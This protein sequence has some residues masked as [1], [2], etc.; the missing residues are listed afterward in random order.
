MNRRAVGVS[1]P[2]ISNVGCLCFDHATA[3]SRTHRPAYADRSPVQ[4]PADANWSTIPRRFLQCSR[5]ATQT[6]LQPSTPGANRDRESRREQRTDR[7]GRGHPPARLAAAG[8]SLTSPGR[9]PA[10]ARSKTAWRSP[11]SGTTKKSPGDRRRAEGAQGGRQAA[12]GMLTA[13]DDAQAMLEMADEDAGLAAEVPGELDRLER[14]LLESGVEGAAQRP[15]RLERRDPHDQRPRRRHRRQRLGRNAAADVPALGRR[16]R[17]RDRAAR[18]AGQR[19]GRHQQRHDRRPRADGLRLSQGRDRHAPPGADQPLQRRRQ[20]ADQLRRGR[21]L[22]R[23]H[24]H[25]RHRN[26]R[27]RRARGRVPR[28]RRRRAARQQDL[29]RHPADAPAHGHR[30]AVPERA[31]PAQEPGHGA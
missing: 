11:A 29:Q 10:S 1:R 3:Y 26:P 21:R 19:G 6:A 20:A 18:P 8:L 24:R 31:E 12:E 5:S 17:L 14:V 28:Q 25:D 9:K 4:W 2:V 23:G 13:A 16:T 27:R 22:A 7:S 15:A 30:R